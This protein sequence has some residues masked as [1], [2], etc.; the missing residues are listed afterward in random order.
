MVKGST[1]SIIFLILSVVLLSSCS[2]LDRNK[3]ANSD[4]TTNKEILY[5][6][7]IDNYDFGDIS[8]TDA[9]K[10][11][12]IKDKIDSIYNDLM[13]TDAFHYLEIGSQFV[14]FHGDYKGKIDFVYGSNTSMKESNVNQS[15]QSGDSVYYCTPLNAVQIGKSVVNYFELDEKVSLGRAYRDSDFE[16]NENYIPLILGNAYLDVYD[17]GDSFEIYY[18]FTKF[19]GKVIGILDSDIELPSSNVLISVDTYIIMP[20]LNSVSSVESDF[21]L[22]EEVHNSEKTLGVIPYENKSDYSEYKQIIKDLSDKYDMPYILLEGLA[23][24]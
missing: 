1:K 22:F 3:Q 24:N 16:Y 18:L 10:D 15:T 23:D 12:E 19:N 21:P 20:Y 17:I 13:E 7:I 11:P 8:F 14:E 6:Q 4:T 9:M 5:A 2:N